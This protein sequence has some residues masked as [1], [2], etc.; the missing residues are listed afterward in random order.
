MAPAVD[1][2]VPEELKGFDTAVKKWADDCKLEVEEQ[3][4]LLLTSGRLTLGQV[5]DTFYIPVPDTYPQ[6]YQNRL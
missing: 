2:Q 4:N 3:I 5:F 1:A 6:K